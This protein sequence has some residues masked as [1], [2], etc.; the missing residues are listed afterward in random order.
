MQYST[1]NFKTV[2]GTKYA[3]K[4]KKSLKIK[5]LKT[6]K[7]YKM[8]IRAYKN[9]ADGKHVSKWKVKAVKVK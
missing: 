5:K 6:K 8:R 4:T 1:D 9:A 7:K 2:A 3:K